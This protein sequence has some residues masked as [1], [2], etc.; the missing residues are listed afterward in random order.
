MIYVPIK[1]RLASGIDAVLYYSPRYINRVKI[2]AAIAVT[3]IV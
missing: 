2:N 3:R 1:G